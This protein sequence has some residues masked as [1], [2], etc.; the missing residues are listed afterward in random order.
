MTDPGKQ[1]MNEELMQLYREKGVNP[2]S[3]CVPML[4][5]MPI[6]FAFYAMLSVSIELRGQPFALWIQDLSQHDPYYITPILMGISMLW[7]QKMTPMADPAQA[8]VMMITPI[9]FLFFFLW[10]PSGLVIY[11]LMSNLL[12]I[13][14]QYATNRISGGPPA[15][16]P[17]AQ[18]RKVKQ[19]G[20]GQTEGARGNGR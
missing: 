12:G 13:G 2:A 6:L 1:K 18:D 15:K 16:P 5:T 4:L 3:G 10:A 9:M 19:A 14:Q 17:R 20:A 8:K 11:W 7:Q